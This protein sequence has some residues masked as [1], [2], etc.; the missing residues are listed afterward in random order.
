MTQSPQSYGM[1]QVNREQKKRVE[2]DVIAESLSD[3]QEAQLRAAIE[4]S[5][6]AIIDQALK[7]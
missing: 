5:D 1:S 2:E 3:H 6:Q 4:M 7:V